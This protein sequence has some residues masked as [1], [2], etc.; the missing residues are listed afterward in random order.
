MN[1]DNKVSAELDVLG[2]PVFGPADVFPM[3]AEDE[4]EELAADIAEHGLREPLVLADIVDPDTGACETVLVDGR[5]RRAA[6]KM[7]GVM[8]TF[9]TLNGEDPTAY[10]LSSNIHRRH[11]TKG[12]RAMAV[13][14]IYP[15][16]KRGMHSELKNSTGMVDK[17]YVS[18]ARTVLAHKPDLAPNVLVGAV[19]LDA[20]Y[21]EA[22]EEKKRNEGKGAQ[23][24]NLR[25]RYPELADKVAEGE[26]SLPAARL[27]ADERDAQE[28]ERRETVFR[29]VEDTARL[30]IGF[31]N[32]DYAAGAARILSD[33]SARADLLRRI[34]QQ[35][36]V[37]R[38]TDIG[39][40]TSLLR[41]AFDRILE[42]VSRLDGTS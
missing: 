12:Q 26:L 5:N 14:R 33:A 10:V 31:A 41:T 40:F 6:C 39:E 16:P 13:A 25:T 36:Q 21:Q 4:L 20:A 34:H 23:L 38:E 29:A 11:M 2:V 9:R 37:L 17:A 28:R 7:A 18:K 3:M 32:D 8:P 35:H 22:Q 19:P 24:V 42:T 1:G 27:E 30:A 15:E